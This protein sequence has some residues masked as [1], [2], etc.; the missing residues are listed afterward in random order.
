M[1]EVGAAVGAQRRDGLMVILAHPDDEAFGVSGSLARATNVGHPAAVICATRGEA[2]EIANPA[3]AT[4]QTLGQV[5]ERELRAACATLGVRDVAFLDYVDGQLSEAD[6]DEAVGRIVRHLRRFCPAIVV[7][8]APNGIYG[9][10]DHMAIHRLVLAAVHAA[11]DPVRYVEQGDEGQRAHRARKVY[12]C[13]PPRERL[14]AL[15]EAAQRQG[16]DFLPGGNAA[17]IPI[18]Q[19][20]TPEREITTRVVLSEAEFAAKQRAMRAHATQL[21]ADSIW[22]T[23]TP[24]E[25]RAD[26]GVES[27]VLAQPPVSDRAYPTPEDD[28]FAGM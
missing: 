23:A 18:E 13:A 10:P 14:L 2:G 17:T 19:M 7:T 5:R 8:F 9:H 15:R 1:N 24:E 25:L 26:V 21:A 22:V 27:F 6:W 11:A 4:P 20:G 3:L 12:Y 28:L 16:E